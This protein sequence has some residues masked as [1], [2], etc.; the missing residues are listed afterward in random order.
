[1]VEQLRV[2]LFIQ[3]FSAPLKAGSNCPRP[4]SEG[5]LCLPVL[6]HS[7]VEAFASK[8]EPET[9][10]GTHVLQLLGSTSAYMNKFI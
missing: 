6:S 5:R 4:R 1:M 10:D 7:V 8:S 2:L 3:P 9:L